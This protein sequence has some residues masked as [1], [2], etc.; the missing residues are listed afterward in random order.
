LVLD[1]LF[2]AS[3]FAIAALVPSAPGYATAV[4]SEAVALIF[5]F[6][7]LLKLGWISKVGFNRPREWRDLRVL[8]LPAMVVAVLFLLGLGSPFSLQSVII[9]VLVAILVGMSEESIFRGVMLQALL[10]KGVRT[11]VV[12]SAVGFSIVHLDN[13]VQAN[14]H[15]S[16]GGVFANALYAFLF[17]VGLAAVRIR[18]NTIWPA[19]TM[20]ALTDVPSLLA[21]VGGT[22]SISSGTPGVAG[23]VLE[24]SLGAIVAGYGLFLLRGRR[25]RIGQKSSSQSSY[26][27]QIQSYLVRA[28]TSYR[29]SCVES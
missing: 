5:A 25:K 26:H 9:S 21:I 11:A 15:A 18:T 2:L 8:W 22:A 19:V 23:I 16:V 7:L 3:G 6:A 4:G 1:A 29:H 17:G 20:H 27:G 24:A 28:T 14:A 12:L 10:P 13:L